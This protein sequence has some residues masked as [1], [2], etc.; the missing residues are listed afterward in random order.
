MKDTD[1][2]VINDPTYFH[3]EA[4]EEGSYWFVVESNGEK[5]HF[6]FTS[7]DLAVERIK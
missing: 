3:F 5:L 4:M 7:K 2:I 6:R 1:D